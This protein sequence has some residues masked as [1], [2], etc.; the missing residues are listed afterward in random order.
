MEKRVIES[1][2]IFY[3]RSET[4][5][6]REIEAELVSEGFEI[7]YDAP[8]SEDYRDYDRVMKLEKER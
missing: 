6:A 4:E 2:E 3:N 5:S 8:C 7:K 1:V